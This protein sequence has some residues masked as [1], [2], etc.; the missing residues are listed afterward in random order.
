M[1]VDFNKYALNTII[2]L[3]Y[4]FTVN[5]KRNIINSDIKYICNKIMRTCIVTYIPTYNTQVNI[6][7]FGRKP[8]W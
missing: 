8:I 6:L 4:V 3:I 1:Y 2:Y 5:A 7:L